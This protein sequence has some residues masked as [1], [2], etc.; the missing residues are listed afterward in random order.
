MRHKSTALIQS[1]F[2]TL[3]TLLLPVYHTLCNNGPEPRSQSVCVCGRYLLLA[4]FKFRLMTYMWFCNQGERKHTRVCLLSINRRRLY[5]LI[6]LVKGNVGIIWHPPS[7]PFHHHM[8]KLF[9]AADVQMFLSM[10]LCLSV[11]IDIILKMG[12]GNL[13]PLFHWRLET[14]LVGG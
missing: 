1:A 13:H 5:P 3:H 8:L 9:S 7:L 14:C 12:W 6:I 4:L 11:T 2:H 10:I